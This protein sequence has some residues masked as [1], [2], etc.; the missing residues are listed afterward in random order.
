MV[1]SRLPASKPRTQSGLLGVVY[2]VVEKGW[3]RTLGG[4]EA[5]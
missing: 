3:L 1:P 4:R 2:T 5:V